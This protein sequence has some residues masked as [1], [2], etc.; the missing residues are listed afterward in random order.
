MSNILQILRRQNPNSSCPTIVDITSNQPSTS[1]PPKE[2]VY[3]TKNTK[4]KN[5]HKEIP[6]KGKED[7][8][9]QILASKIK[10]LQTYKVSL[11]FNLGPE[12]TKLK[13]L[14]PL[15]EL[16]RNETYKSQIN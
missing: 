12:I 15:T 8:S 2:P 7:N 1:I 13:I 6:N 5:P 10:K 11:P 14:V 4:S 3:K 16:I 9:T